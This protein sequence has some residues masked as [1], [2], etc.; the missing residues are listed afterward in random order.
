[1][2]HL[3]HLVACLALGLTALAS[4][5]EFGG[6]GM[7]NLGGWQAS[8]LL[9]P[10][11]L[12]AG[13][14]GVLRVELK[15]T[16]RHLEMARA[17][18]PGID[19]ILL[20]VTAE[21]TFDTTGRLRLPGGHGIS[22]LLTPAGLPIEGGVFGAV[23]RYTDPALTSP[24]DVLS[25]QPLPVTP[26]KDGAM[27]VAFELPL[28]MPQEAPSGIYRLRLDFGFRAGQQL[29]SLNAE[30]FARHSDQPVKSHLYSPPF[31]PVENKP[32]GI[33]RIP[34]SLLCRENSN[35][36]RGVVSE[37]DKDWYNLSGRFLIQDDVIL[38]LLDATG[39]P[40]KYSL[41]PCFAADMAQPEGAIP[42][43]PDAG[44]LSVQITGPDGRLVDLGTH[45]FRDK[46]DSGLSS[47]LPLLTGW[48]PPA[49]GRYEARVNG[50]V[51]DIWGNRYAGGGVYRFWIAKRMTL[52]TATF[53]GMSY[54][55]GSQYG[56]TITF[57]P[58]VPAEVDYWAVLYPAS[59]RES[60][61]RIAGHGVAS[62]AGSFGPGQGLK[63]LPLDTPGEY[64]AH[65]L[66]RY[67]DKG[68]HLWVCTMRHAG[69]VYPSNTPLQAHGKKLHVGE[70][71]LE[72]GATGQEGGGRSV[73]TG[74]YPRFIVNFPYR[75]GDVALI[76]SE[77]ASAN[78]VAGVLTA[79]GGSSPAAGPESLRGLGATNLRTRTHNGYSAHL[80]P[81]FIEQWGYYYAA[82]PRP[83]LS[84]LFLVAEDGVRQPYWVMSPNDFGGQINAS[85]NGDSPGDIYRLVGGVVLR[86]SAGDAEY[87]GY[88]ANAFVLPKG[89]NNNRV[90]APGSENLPGA[91]GSV[92]RF[93]LAG[94][95]PGLLFEVGQILTPGVQVDPN[96]PAIITC[97]LDFPDGRT[98]SA[99]GIPG[100]DGS[101]TPETPWRLDMPGVYRYFVE[102][103][104][105]GHK[106]RMPGLP[107]EGGFLFVTEP[108]PAPAGSGL[109]L[110][111][112]DDS[113][114]TSATV[115]I[116]G[117]TTSD[118]V[119]YQYLIPG[120]VVEQGILPVQKG[121]F[122]LA[123]DAAAIHRRFPT[124]DVLRQTAFQPER[125]DV[126][127]LTFFS[128]E[129]NA[130]GETH[131][132]H[133]RLII[134]GDRILNVQ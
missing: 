85:S 97:R 56:R 111:L 101:F 7:T 99:Q 54:P 33:P 93:W 91:D 63:P 82:A 84:S 112:P 35:G 23:S 49:Y 69:I 18:I 45:P 37:Q 42:W 55:V 11:V 95:R 113:H 12:H 20:L 15:L 117:Q 70:Q 121:K 60:V 5:V 44:F 19:G 34:W 126:I 100:P 31:R 6:S 66:A 74:A 16:P 129:R 76:A 21:R 72:R 86:N 51:E 9:N 109:C 102:G 77:Q 89:S 133:R 4:Q 105:Q 47:G 27:H 61:R 92:A 22:M 2:T 107:E 48:Q 28:R 103:E 88:L 8:C 130:E 41:E 119:W 78:A 30:L 52:S 67:T 81:E 90:I 80:Y 26:A 65:V 110:D 71:E 39:Q 58:S 1:M 104:W 79:S 36:Y 13:E 115:T 64:F 132:S 32:S 120:A 3:R 98:I 114:S 68:G 125:K 131:Y 62:R 24:I 94:L 50:W 57:A 122:A 73:E 53:Q 116:S 40:A 75:S 124:Y 106:G 134:R 46:T 128:R 127:H 43:K 118:Q 59:R 25:V 87:A 17:A 14:T 83:G 96:L 123:L 29:V 38:P 108:A 10:G